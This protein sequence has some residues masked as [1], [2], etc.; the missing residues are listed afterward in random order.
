MSVYNAF[1]VSL[2][3]SSSAMRSCGT[4]V[5]VSDI[6]PGDI[7]CYYGHVG[8]YVGNN[9][10]V[11]ASNPSSG[12]KFTSPINYRTIASVRRILN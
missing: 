11:H 9:T 1:G 6:Q 5:S 3:H 4:A 8:I 12:I 2:P 10:L 7:V